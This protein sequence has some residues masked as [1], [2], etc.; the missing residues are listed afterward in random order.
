[1]PK[2]GVVLVDKPSGITSNEAVQGVKKILGVEKA[3]HT[4]TLGLI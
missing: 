3:G 4:G 2:N 1:M